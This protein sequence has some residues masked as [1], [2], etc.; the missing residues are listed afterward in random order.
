[1]SDP[2]REQLEA[3]ARKMFELSDWPEGGDIDG[4]DFQDAAIAC[5]LLTA[6]KQYKPCGDENTGC[7][8][9]DNFSVLDFDRGV[10]CYRKAEFLAV[11]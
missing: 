2:T 4:F 1:M 9:A 7:Q 8:C 5:G 6:T 3:F 11:K 10:T